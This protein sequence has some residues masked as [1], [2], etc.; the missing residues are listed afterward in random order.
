MSHCAAKLSLIVPDAV[1][2]AV[3]HTLPES[4][5]PVQHYPRVVVTWCTLAFCLSVWGMIL[6]AVGQL[7]A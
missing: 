1:P 5:T 6:L 7:T 4:E 3:P 2:Q